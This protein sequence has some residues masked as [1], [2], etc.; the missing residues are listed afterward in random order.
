MMKRLIGIKLAE[1]IVTEPCKELIF[2][3]KST[4]AIAEGS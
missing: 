2:F 1:N 4:W 3:G